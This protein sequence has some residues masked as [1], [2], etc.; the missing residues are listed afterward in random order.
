MQI[1]ARHTFVIN[2]EGKIVK[3]YTEVKPNEHSAEVLAALA[4][5]QK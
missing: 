3:V 4:E 5:L 1:A 2:P